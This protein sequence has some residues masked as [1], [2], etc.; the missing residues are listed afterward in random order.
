MGKSR[1]FDYFGN[2]LQTV[3]LNHQQQDTE[4]D[5]FNISN[6]SIAIKEPCSNHKHLWKKNEFTN[7]SNICQNKT[8]WNIRH[9]KFSC[10]LDRLIKKCIKF[11][12]DNCKFHF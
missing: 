10:L 2:W 5:Q 4:G 3:F 12:F 6:N 11:T 9:T 8:K 1:I 7:H